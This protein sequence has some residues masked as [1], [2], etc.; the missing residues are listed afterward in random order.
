VS[1]FARIWDGVKN[2][3][4]GLTQVN[5]GAVNLIAVAGI[6]TNPKGP[7]TAQCIDTTFASGIVS[8]YSGL[9]QDTSLRIWRIA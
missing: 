7:I 9:G 8:Q 4:S 2:Y 6:V 1:L 3:A 5:G